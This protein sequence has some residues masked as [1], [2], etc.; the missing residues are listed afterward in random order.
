MLMEI[1]FYLIIEIKIIDTDNNATAILF[2]NFCSSCKFTSVVTIFLYVCYFFL[3]A[4]AFANY[5]YLKDEIVSLVN[6]EVLRLFCVCGSPVIL[7]G[8][9]VREKGS[10]RP[11]VG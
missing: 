4:R 7:G 2:S 11:A 1:K 6:R 3:G 9:L 5:K 8:K 10:A